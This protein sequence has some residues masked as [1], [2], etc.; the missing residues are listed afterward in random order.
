M[1]NQPAP[2]DQLRASDAPPKDKE[3][4][5]LL[6][7]VMLMGEHSRGHQLKLLELMR[8]TR[9]MRHGKVFE[10]RTYKAYTPN[11]QEAVTDDVKNLHPSTTLRN[12]DQK[13]LKE[14]RNATAR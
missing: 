14:L 3:G 5:Q 7:M 1:M 11:Q 10:L 4:Q 13:C 6:I 12:N 8:R 9:Y 2:G